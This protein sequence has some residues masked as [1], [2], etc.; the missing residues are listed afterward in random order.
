M[1]TTQQSG[2]STGQPKAVEL[3]SAVVSSVTEHGIAPSGENFELSN[4][5]S[6]K[7]AIALDDCAKALKKFYPQSDAAFKVVKLEQGVSIAIQGFSPYIVTGSGMVYRLSDYRHNTGEIPVTFDGSG[8]PL[9]K[10]GA[11]LEPCARI[12]MVGDG[13]VVCAPPG[14]GPVTA[15]SESESADTEEPHSV[16]ETLSELAER[17]LDSIGALF[18]IHPTDEIVAECSWSAKQ[19]IFLQ[20][21]ETG[22]ASGPKAGSKRDVLVKL[23][24]TSEGEL[25]FSE[26]LEGDADEESFPWERFVETELVTE[27]WK[28]TELTKG[29]E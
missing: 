24:I 18:H 3:S 29:A 22:G 26:A 28:F 13:H 23:S 20:D 5:D 11:P 2:T 14:I 8:T 6:Q 17:A 19:W 25:K 1:S 27:E 4:F 10:D 16:L 15:P 12:I 9:S 7:V 21:V